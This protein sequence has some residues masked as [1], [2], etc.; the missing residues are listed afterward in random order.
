M[1]DFWQNDDPEAR[2]RDRLHQVV[3]WLVALMVALAG[4]YALWQAL[5]PEV[6]IGEPA[7]G[8]VLQI[9]AE[10]PAPAVA[11]SRAFRELGATASCPGECLVWVDEAGT[12]VV[13][14]F[15]A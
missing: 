13:L 11:I 15:G 6:E 7:V 12:V 8:F 10:P 14:R 3:L 9:P 4:L 5:R 1:T 2:L